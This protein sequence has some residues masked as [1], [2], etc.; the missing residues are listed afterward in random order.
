MECNSHYQRATVVSLAVTV[1]G[2]YVL[3][4]VGLSWA[5]IRSS[6]PENLRCGWVTRLL[7]SYMV[8]ISFS[9]PK[10]K[11]NEHV[12]EYPLLL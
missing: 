10:R 4:F 2:F 9:T 6:A 5:G 3:Y 8:L 7:R 12:A 11:Q 1:L